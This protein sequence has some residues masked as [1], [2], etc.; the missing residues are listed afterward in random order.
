MTLGLSVVTHVNTSRTIDTTKCFR[1]IK[2]ELPESSN[3]III[4]S[5]GTNNTS[6]MLSRFDSMKLNDIIVFVDDDDYIAPGSLHACLDAL[7]N[8]D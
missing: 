4:E 5:D 6:F 3:H 7:N 1:S 2:D 8:N